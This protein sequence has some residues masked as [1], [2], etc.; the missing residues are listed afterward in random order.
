MATRDNSALVLIDPLND[1]LHPNGK[2]Y[3]RMESSLS[4]SS[5]LQHIQELVAAARRAKI[6][7]FYGLHQ[8]TKAETYEGWKH[9][10][11]NQAGAKRITLFDE[12]FGGNVYEGLEP[13]FSNGD[14]VASRHW[15]SSSFANSDLDY[16]LR[17]KDIRYLTIV[18]MTT[19]TCVETTARY[20][21]ELGYDVTLIN[22]ATGAF[23]IA[24]EEAAT[25]LVWPLLAERVISTAEWISSLP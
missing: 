18:G 21:R 25:G 17:Q 14:V 7:V 20:A 22:D 5:A 19:N 24:L 4:H 23:S 6:P 16:Q 3:P 2:L 12:E 8:H 15:N 10:N 1:F 11:A 9:M 13:D